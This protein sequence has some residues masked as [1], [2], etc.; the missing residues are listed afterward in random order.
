MV[1]ACY[2]NAPL[3]FPDL[4]ATGTRVPAAEKS[5]EPATACELADQRAPSAVLWQNPL[6]GNGVLLQLQALSFSARSRLRGTDLEPLPFQSV[7]ALR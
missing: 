2:Q 3:G 5:E 7:D 6:T 1:H 4:A